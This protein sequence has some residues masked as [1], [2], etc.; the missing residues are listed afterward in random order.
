MN[1]D[2][3]FSFLFIGSTMHRYS[4]NYKPPES[5]KTENFENSVGKR[6]R[7]KKN[8]NQ[9]LHASFLCFVSVCIVCSIA[10]AYP[11]CLPASHGC[12]N[13]N[14]YVSASVICNAV[15]HSIASH[16]ERASSK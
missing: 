15:Y 3:H 1:N 13:V 5:L 10:C 7:K 12:V 14:A 9:M 4:D 11:A 6:T 16:S 2:E 8:H